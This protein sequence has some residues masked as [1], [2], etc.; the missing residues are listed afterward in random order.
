MEMMTGLR[1]RDAVGV[2]LHR[3]P[4]PWGHLLTGFASTTDEHIHHLEV[5]HENSKRWFNLHKAAIPGPVPVDHPVEEARTSQVMLMED[6]TNLET[7]EAELAHSERLASIG[8][9][10]AGVA[11]EIGNPVTGIA[12]L[13][14]N[15]RHEEEPEVVRESIEEI[16]QQT[17]RITAIV[18]TLMNF[19]RSGGIGT[20]I[21]RFTIHEVAD[22]AI[23]LVQLTHHGRQISCYNDCPASL[24][25][26]GDRQGLSQVLVN[27]LTNACDASPAGGEV[28]LSAD[29]QGDL[30][31][32]EVVDMGEGIP[33]ENQAYIFEPFFTTKP[34]GEGTGLGL[35]MT[36]KIIADHQGAISVTS[37][38]GEG[39][40]VTIELPKA[41]QL[42]HE[43]NISY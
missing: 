21:R 14:Q 7:L 9:L 35:A 37:Q 27:L 40:R 38:P 28:R 5:D 42:H 13:A 6:L 16:L 17:R 1:A 18:K 29:E 4:P 22:E 36:Y 11:H 2:P 39:T 31:V 3:L 26:E 41:S 25:L 23:R 34:P 30:V 20:D 32:I 33:E 15:L 19:S 10:A 43:P 12:S 8:R 24:A